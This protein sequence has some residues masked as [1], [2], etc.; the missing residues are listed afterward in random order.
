MEA[1][2]AKKDTKSSEVVAEVTT[3]KPANLNRKKRVSDEQL[4][5]NTKKAKIVKKF[6]KLATTPKKVSLYF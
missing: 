1:E 5:K 6:R 2:T 4:E 3:I